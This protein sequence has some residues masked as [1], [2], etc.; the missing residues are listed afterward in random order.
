VRTVN[1][2]H[3]IKRQNKRPKPPLFRIGTI[4]ISAFQHAHE[5]L[6]REILRL[7]GRVT[8]AANIGV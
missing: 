6:L 2:N 7:I 5:E 3:T 8:A 4:E 1:G